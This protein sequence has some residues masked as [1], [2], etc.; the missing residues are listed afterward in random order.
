[1]PGWATG[2]HTRR[3]TD[4]AARAAALGGVIGPA[5]FIGAWAVGSTNNRGYSIIDDAISRLA[6]VGAE[7]RPLMTTGFVAFGIGVPL[8]ATAL[9]HVTASR[10]WTTGV[11][12]GLATIAVAAVPLG[13]SSA[14]DTW[15]GAFATIGYVTLAVTPLL[16][17][18]SLVERGHRGLA[19][20]GIVSAAVSAT[21]LLLSTTRLPT[22]LF[23]RIGLT[24]GDIWIVASALAI[25]SGRLRSDPVRRNAS[26]ADR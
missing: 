22:G 13:Q 10:V 9:G 15:H 20:L 25:V 17:V 1:V 2:A 21:S 4:V 24:A 6:Q 18:R 14:A 11:A 7:T 19:R 8:F 5:A 16:A 12:T 23:Q 3:S 26:P